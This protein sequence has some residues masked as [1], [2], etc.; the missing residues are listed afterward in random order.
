MN[1]IY[2]NPSAEWIEN[3]L[4]P[5]LFQPKKR[6]ADRVKASDR[7]KRLGGALEVWRIFINWKK[8]GCRIP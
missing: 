6:A 8:Q 5:F 1:F 4:L 7:V 3:K 2:H